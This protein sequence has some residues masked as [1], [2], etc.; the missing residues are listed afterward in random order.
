M[1]IRKCLLALALAASM[2][3]GLTGC[4]SIQNLAEELVLG[5]SNEEFAQKLVQGNLDEIYLGQFDEEYLEMVDISIVDAKKDYLD[6]ID[7]EAEF[8]ANY[9]GIVVAEYDEYYADL[10]DDFKNTV[11]EMYQEIYSHSKYEVHDAVKQDDSTYSVKVVIYPIDIMEQA[12]NA[13][14]TYAPLNAFFEKYADVDF[15][16][17]SDEDYMAY[18][19]EYGYLIVDLVK[20]QLPNLS[21]KEPESMLVQVEDINDVFQMNES[22]LSIFD[23]YVIYYP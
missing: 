23:E 10:N 17:M 6:G 7:V 1:K 22:D 11:S 18:T 15:N 20:E 14:D 19:H 5:G 8:F 3:L 16:T 2:I 9:W 13:Y 12:A 21:Y 4:G